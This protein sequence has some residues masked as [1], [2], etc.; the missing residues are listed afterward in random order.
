MRL[1][2]QGQY[3]RAGELAYGV[4]PGL[5]KEL[6]SLEGDAQADGGGAMME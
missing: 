1:Q 5:E 6:A 4:I 3:Q 2:R